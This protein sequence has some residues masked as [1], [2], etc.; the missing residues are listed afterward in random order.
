MYFSSLITTHANVT[1][2]IWFVCGTMTS[3]HEMAD[4][5]PKCKI[6]WRSSTLYICLFSLAAAFSPF[7]FRSYN[8]LFCASSILLSLLKM[9]ANGLVIR[10]RTV[11]YLP[12]LLAI[13]IS[14]FYL[15]IL[16]ITCLMVY[17]ASSTY[18]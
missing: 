13:F 10:L 3:S 4:L 16:S 12:L 18:E 2:V 8:A 6:E 7:E 15:L 11:S 17:G 1:R 5:I 9:I 14:L